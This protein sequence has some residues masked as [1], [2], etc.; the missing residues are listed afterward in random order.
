MIPIRG[1]TIAGM[2]L[3]LDYVSKS[4]FI[5]KLLTP[6]PTTIPLLPFLKLEPAWNPGVSFGIFRDLGIHTPIPFIIMSL[7]ISLGLLY[8]MIKTS[9]LYLHVA[10]GFIIG[11]ALGNVLDRIFYDAVFDFI[12]LFYKN[13]TWPNFNVADMAIVLGCFMLII[14]GVF[15]KR[16]SV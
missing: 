8:W 3:L 15:F 16:E 11:G 6:M 13:Y 10:I 12:A 1:L 4:Y 14:D 7:V 9:S 5:G 2:T